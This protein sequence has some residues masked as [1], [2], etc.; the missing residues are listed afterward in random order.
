MV[1]SLR[2]LTWLRSSVK[3]ILTMVVSR[4]RTGISFLDSLGGIPVNQIITICGP[5]GSGKT[6]LTLLIT[7]RFLED[8]F[9]AKAALIDPENTVSKLDLLQICRKNGISEYVLNNLKISSLADPNLILN[10]IKALLEC[11]DTDLNVLLTIDSLP[12]IFIGT[13]RRSKSSDARPKELQRE[14]YQFLSNL[15]S[16]LEGKNYVL[17]LVD[18]LRSILEGTSVPEF[19]KKERS[20]PA[21]WN[22]LQM[23][24]D[25]LIFLKKVRKGLFLLR[26]VYSKYLPEIIGP[27]K[28]GLDIII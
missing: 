17:I 4:F 6:L 19:W 15:Q 26:I 27:F 22:V 9:N 2:G 20:I 7:L 3:M 24:T 11:T 25:T 12:S 21:F 13:I 8:M 16:M 14:V 5:P 1:I 28:I 10:N 18:E 23:F